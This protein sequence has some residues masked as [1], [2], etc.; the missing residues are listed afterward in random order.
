[1]MSNLPLIDNPIVRSLGAK[2]MKLPYV[3]DV[4]FFPVIADEPIT[5]LAGE[6]ALFF[7]A[8]I[9]K[10]NSLIKVFVTVPSTIYLDEENHYVI[11]DRMAKN[12]ENA[13]SGDDT[14]PAAIPPPP[15]IIPSITEEVPNITEE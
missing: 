12:I 11:V 4:R 13:I 14:T 8:L 5:K 9:S 1:M 7:V 3:I 15:V 2:L 6:D 10:D